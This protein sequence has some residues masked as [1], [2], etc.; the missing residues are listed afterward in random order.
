MAISAF[1]FGEVLL[2][3]SM[4]KYNVA[5]SADHDNIAGKTFQSRLCLPGPI[6]VVYT[7]VNGSDPVLISELNKVKSQLMSQLN[8]TVMAK[9]E[10]GKEKTERA[11][12]KAKPGSKRPK[13]TEER[14]KWND[15][16]ACP[17]PN[18]VPFNAIAVSGLPRNISEFLLSIENTFLPGFQFSNFENSVDPSVKVLVFRENFNIET[19]K[20]HTVKFKNMERKFSRVFVSSTIRMGASKVDGIGI[21]NYVPKDMT[22]EMIEN[23][24]HRE[25]INEVSISITSNVSV[26]KFDNLIKAKQ[27]L[28][29]MRG[30]IKINGHKFKMLPATFIWKPLT[31]LEIGRDIIEEDVSTSRFADNEELRYSLRSVEKYAPWIRNIYIVTNGQIPSWLNLDHPR[32]KVVTHEEIFSN[33][34]HLPTF[35]SPAIETHI[36]K[37]PGLSKQFIYMNDDVFFGDYVWPDDFYTHSS[38]QKLYLTWPVPNCNEGCPASWVND[39]YCDKPCNVSECDW[40]GGDCLNTQ[41][42]SGF[43]SHSIPNFFGGHGYS[44]IGEYCNG[45]CANSWIG[46]RYCDANCNV[47]NCG[48]DAGD[49]GILKFKDMFSIDAAHLNGVLK[50]PVGIKAFFINFT[51]ILNDGILSEGDY[52]ESTVIRAA[53]FSKK[54]KTMTVTFYANFTAT[55]PFSVSGFKDKNQTIPVSL[56]FSISV[57]T[58]KEPLTTTAKTSTKKINKVKASQKPYTV[59]NIVAKKHKQSEYDEKSV[60]GNKTMNEVFEWYKATKR[61]IPLEV[62]AELNKTEIELKDGYLTENG[63]NKRKFQIIHPFYE[64]NGNQSLA[65]NQVIMSITKSD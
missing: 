14:F 56:N 27:F 24:L 33:K 5:F 23:A 43:P 12:N 36:H 65:I 9:N 45:G 40:D 37:I 60:H 47:P 38:G 59:Y 8:L 2:E 42:K 32:I 18:C 58:S 35:S 29:P 6:D 34:S 54:F 46:D 11:S 25:K 53:I 63:Y 49:C 4:Q 22:I 7:W 64:S 41:G 51:S 39:K 1:Q 10:K 57:D 28:G 30:K 48:Y 52:V 31:P 50:I 20:N 16:N 17:Y 44:A 19:L 3:W 61:D 21:I 13:N 15:E 55:V 26:I 62:V